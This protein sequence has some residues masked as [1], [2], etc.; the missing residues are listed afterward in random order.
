MKNFVNDPMS[1]AM[2]DCRVNAL[3]AVL[4]VLPDQEPLDI[5]IEGISPNFL[6]STDKNLSK[7]LTE[8]FLV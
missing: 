8:I 1:C 6:H 3:S 5:R 2:N 7:S 4:L